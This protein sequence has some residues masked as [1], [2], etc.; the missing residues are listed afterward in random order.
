MEFSRQEYR[1][2]LP[3]P[4]PGDLPNSGI[5]PRSPVLAGGFFT[6]VPRGKPQPQIL[7]YPS[8]LCLLLTSLRNMNLLINLLSYWGIAGFRVNVC[9]IEKWSSYI[10][11][12]FHILFQHDLSQ[13]TGFS[14]PCYTVGLCCLSIL[15]AIVGICWS[16]TPNPSLPTGATTSLLSRSVSRVLFRR[17][18]HS[19]LT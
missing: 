12:L 4:P 18:V 16:Q 3:F 10:Y 15:F 7:L 6:T 2:G 17:L 13:D 9:C 1:S 5:E 8:D 19:C 11:N 14:S